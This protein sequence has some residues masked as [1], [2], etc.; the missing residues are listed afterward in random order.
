MKF[1]KW[2]SIAANYYG[3]LA[4]KMKDIL[5]QS[6]KKSIGISIS[7]QLFALENIQGHFAFRVNYIEIMGS[8]VQ[9]HFDNI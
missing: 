2:N 5:R 4:L 7:F 9:Q 6:L 1:I 3:A 8:G